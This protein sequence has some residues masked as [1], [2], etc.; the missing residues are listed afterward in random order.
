MSM[1]WVALIVF[2]ASCAIFFM[3]FLLFLISCFSIYRTGKY[4]YKDFE[5]FTDYFKKGGLQAQRQGES[6]AGSSN[7]IV[8]N[9]EKISSDVEDIQELFD[10]VQNSPYI[11][12]GKTATRLAR[13]FR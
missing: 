3:S 13:R 5:P 10:E 12:A 11:K 8:V 1:G 7:E 2:G 6:I 4:A 9:V